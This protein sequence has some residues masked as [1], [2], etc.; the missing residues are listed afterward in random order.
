M[1]LPQ[2]RV[3]AIFLVGAPAEGRQ[4]RRGSKAAFDRLKRNRL[5]RERPDFRGGAKDACSG[6]YRP[7]VIVRRRAGG[8]RAAPAR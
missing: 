2:S 4:T 8:E 7:S 3:G 5:E 6:S 1:N